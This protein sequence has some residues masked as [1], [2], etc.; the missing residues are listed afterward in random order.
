VR[1]VPTLHEIAGGQYQSKPVLAKQRVM[2]KM[3]FQ[4]GNREFITHQQKMHEF[5]ML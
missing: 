5:D 4:S 1:I 2:A 3:G